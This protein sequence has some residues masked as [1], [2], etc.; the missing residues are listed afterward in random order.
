MEWA[1]LSKCC[2]INWEWFIC[3]TCCSIYDKYSSVVR[4][5]WVCKH[6]WLS[7]YITYIVLVTG[8]CRFSTLFKV[9]CVNHRT[10][11]VVVAGAGNCKLSRFSTN[12][13]GNNVI[14]HCKVFV[15]KSWVNSAHNG[16]PYYLRVSGVALRCIIIKTAPNNSCVVR[17]EAC[18][19]CILILCCCTRFTG[20]SNTVKVCCSTCSG[21][22]NILHGTG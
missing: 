17:G 9:F 7:T 6:M 3:G 15:C 1:I 21:C 16:L 10:T 14:R 19:D 12:L 18:K 22:H 8:F 11:R 2:W 4:A 13:N 5:G 20:Y